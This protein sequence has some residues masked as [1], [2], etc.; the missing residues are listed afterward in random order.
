M[1]KNN[2]HR[3]IQ[4]LKNSEIG[5]W[6]ETLPYIDEL[7][8]IGKFMH[9]NGLKLAEIKGAA[10]I[11]SIVKSTGVQT[12]TLIEIGNSLKN[13]KAPEVVLRWLGHL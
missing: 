1:L 11:A 3:W 9:E 4:E 2:V 8:D 12:D 6:K 7:A 10:V 5:T 13:V